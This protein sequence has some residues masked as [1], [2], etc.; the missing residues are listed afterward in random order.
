[1][2]AG[3][4]LFLDEVAELPP[5]VQGKLLR[6]LQER[7]YERVGGTATLEADVRLIAATNRDLDAA[8]AEGRFRDDLYYR[9]AVFPIRL[10]ALRE[11]GQD[12]LLL[13]EHFLRTVSVRM[14][15]Q[16]PGLSDEACDLLLAHSW[17]GNI[18]ELQNAIERALILA[19][20]HL[21]SAEQLGIVPR[22][23]RDVAAAVAAPPAKDPTAMP[24]LAEQQ[25]RLIFETLQ[26][27]NGNKARAAAALGLSRTQLLR[28]IR[29]L[30]LDV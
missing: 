7:Q 6:V 10:P 5:S 24:T 13:S 23:P 21:I 18:R 30:K 11:R 22:P 16:K 19:Q 8:V 15:R 27:T 29:R 17:P 3:G 12:I 4:T 1:L 26:R 20:G 28:R 25:T 9:L 2:A 14:G